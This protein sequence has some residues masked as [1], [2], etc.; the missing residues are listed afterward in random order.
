[1]L[2]RLLTGIL[3][4]CAAAQAA[5]GGE[6]RAIHVKYDSCRHGFGDETVTVNMF[7]INANGDTT[8][9]RVKTL[10]LERKES[11]D[12]SLIQFMDPPDVR[13]A[14][15]LTYQNPRGEDQQWL[16]LPELRRVKV[17]SSQNKSGSFMG[18]EFAYE[19]ITG[20]S[21]D[22][23]EY[24][25]IGEADL[26]GM[27]CHLIEKKPLFTSGYVRVKEWIDKEK[28]LLRR[29]EMIDRKG[30]LLKVELDEDWRLYGNTWKSDRLT[31]IN[32]QTGKK[33]VLVFSDR[34]H[35]VGLKEGDFT[36]PS[37]QRVRF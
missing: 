22:K 25:K 30:S 24:R 36:Q 27:P 16:Y 7:L 35:R 9:R 6:G 37:M 23:F 20:N 17:I 12:Y 31:M 3:L 14:G 29:A 18:S 15:L 21:L 28:C 19:D 2:T 13:G 26:E 32:L 33:T 4:L 11:F 8:T 1:M 5:D 10:I 34:K